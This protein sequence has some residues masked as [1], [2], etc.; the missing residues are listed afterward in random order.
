MFGLILAEAKR[1]DLRLVGKNSDNKEKPRACARGFLLSFAKQGV[2]GPFPVRCLGVSC[3]RHGVLEI[4]VVIVVIVVEVVFSG[5][6]GVTV[7][8]AA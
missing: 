1:Y 4:K 7:G 5:V 6:E 8:S 3:L 2:T